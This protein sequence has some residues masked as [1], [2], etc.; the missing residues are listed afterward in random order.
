MLF[1]QYYFSRIEEPRSI[2]TIVVVPSYIDI[3]PETIEK[4]FK[5]YKIGLWVIDVDRNEKQ[6]VVTAEYLRKRMGKEFIESVNNPK[7]MGKEI[8]EISKEIGVDESAFKRAIEKKSEDFATFFEQYVLESVDAIAEIRPE[9]IGRRYIDRKL[10]DF[11]FDLDN[12]AYGTKLRDLVN[13]HLTQKGDDYLFSRNCFESLWP[14]Y[15]DGMEFPP[16]LERFEA[17]LQHFF[18]EYREHFIHQFQVFLLGTI[19]IGHLLQNPI[20]L[21]ENGEIDVKINNFARGWLLASSIH[22]FTYPLQKYDEW[23]SEFFRQQLSIDEPLSFLELKGIYVEKTFLTRVEHLLSKLEKDFVET[24]D[25]EEAKFYNEIR[26]FFYYA[27]AEKKNHGLMGG[28]YL[29][30]RFEEKD[31]E[32]FSNVI[33]PA[34][35]AS[36]IHDAE[37]W[38][39]LSGQPNSDIDKKWEYIAGILKIAKNE[40]IARVLADPNLNLEGKNQQIVSILRKKDEWIGNI[41][42][43]ISNIVMKKPLSKLS[44][45]SQPLAFLLILCDNLQDCGRP[46]ENENLRKAMEAADIRLK[47][48]SFDPK[49]S[50]LTIQLFFNDTIE[51]IGFM[52]GKVAIWSKIKNFLKST[53]IKFVIEYWD[54]KIDKEAKYP[55]TIG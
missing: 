13:K 15:F 17:F 31:R 32:E 41:Y 35:V 45:K 55:F 49:S 36:A 10:L 4:F 40:D 38:Q 11:M 30:K 18:P 5:D 28:S 48:I 12:V 9:Q 7:D 53:D 14:D 1:Y 21:F 47:N 24:S 27:I 51:S 25:W 34:A 29:L 37:I 44:L 33:L 20:N 42:A 8:K 50:T 23:S 54:R 46:C 19:I 2:R 22:D 39:T 6:E 3:S 26:R 43:D 52:G 16:T